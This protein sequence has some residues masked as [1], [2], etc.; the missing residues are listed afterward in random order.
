MPVPAQSEW[1]RA[2]LKHPPIGV[3]R[4]NNV[5]RGYVLAQEGRFLDD[6][7]GEF[8]MRS[9][10]QIVKLAR[11]KPNGL[12]ARFTH[13]TLS[14]DGLGTFLGRTRNVQLGVVQV[15]RNGEHLELNAVRGDL[16]LDPTAFSTPNGDLGNYIMDLAESDP[17]A[18]SS[19]LVVKPEERWRLEKGKRATDE[20][21]VELPPI[22]DPIEL[23][24]SDVVDSGAAV[25]GFL[26]AEGLSDQLVRDGFKMLN[27]FLPGATR[28]VVEARLSTWLTRALDLR[29]GTEP[30]P[31]VEPLPPVEPQLH[32]E[33][34]ERALRLKQFN[35]AEIAR[36]YSLPS[37]AI[38]ELTHSA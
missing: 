24:A 6:R 3:D 23:H 29:F 26:S 30:E 33:D 37:H 31:D 32:A 18:F 9:L 7:P 16:H 10:R 34:L 11:Q 28:D 21:G 25:D 14:G 17:D 15:E 8:D 4:E 20:N 38:D 35:I 36:S 2:D 12:K 22:W 19:S 13:P 5:I 27:G 1:L